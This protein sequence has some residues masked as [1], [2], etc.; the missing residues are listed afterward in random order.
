MAEH[1]RIFFD[2]N[3]GTYDH[4]YLLCL[5]QSKDDLQALGQG[6][7]AGMIVTIF[8]PDELQMSATLHY[9]EIDSVW[10][11]RPIAGTISC[12]DQERE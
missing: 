4:G 12:L 1:P 9:D 10:V 5:D 8:M 6:L 7:R 11:A 2:T 3:E